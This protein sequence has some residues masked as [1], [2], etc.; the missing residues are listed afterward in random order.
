ME[1][2]KFVILIISGSASFIT[3]IIGVI[4]ILIRYSSD[5]QREKER[6]KKE[7]DTAIANISVEADHRLEERSI[8]FS[9][10]IYE[11]NVCLKDISRKIV[12][13]SMIVS[14]F[15][16]YVRTTVANSLR[17]WKTEPEKDV[18]LTKF[19]N[20]TLT[21]DEA[22]LLK[23][24]MIEERKSKIKSDIEIFSTYDTMIIV[25]GLTI[26]RLER[27]Q[28]SNEPCNIA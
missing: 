28:C 14:M 8:K 10:E 6:L 16:N 11:I 2:V 17:T 3:T 9:N 5:K 19:T 25:L 13:H 27:K 4:I 18:L 22:Y 15:E 1:T 20:N 24:Y 21:R 26:Q 23:E 7:L 12:E